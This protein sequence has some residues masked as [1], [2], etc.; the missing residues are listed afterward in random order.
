M[1]LG[2]INTSFSYRTKPSAIAAGRP[3]YLCPK[4]KIHTRGSFHQRIGFWPRRRSGRAAAGRLLL[5]LRGGAARGRGDKALG[6]V[7]A[8]AA[9]LEAVAQGRHQVDDLGVVVSG[10]LGLYDAAFPLVLDQR[11]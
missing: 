10:L 7:A 9:A 1:A 4:P 2:R 3:Q 11:A 6:A 5:A 8:C